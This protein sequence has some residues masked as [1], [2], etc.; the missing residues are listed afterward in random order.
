MASVDY[1]SAGVDTKKAASLIGS[2]KD[3]IHKTATVP[4][5]GKLAEGIGGF[6]GAFQHDQL[7]YDVVSTTDGVGTK[8]QLQKKYNRLPGV[9]YDLVAM[10]VNDLYCAGAVPAFFLDYVACGKLDESWY[11]PV[12]TSIAQACGSVPMALM[13][14][15]T[16]EHPGVMKDDDFDLAGFA[17]G[18]R[19]RGKAWPRLTEMK[20]EHVL[21][22]IP[23][24]GLHSN[25]F[26]LVRRILSL[27]EEQDSGRF[28]ALTADSDFMD[29]LLAPTRIYRG[30]EKLFDNENIFGAAHI[31]GGGIYENL[32]RVIPENLK[33]VF[34]DVRVPENSVYSLLREFTDLEDLFHTFNM[35]HGMILVAEETALPFVQTVFPD[36]WI[37][38][39]LQAGNRSIEIQG[40]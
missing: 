36:A 23:S 5:V 6:A 11:N 27:L 3:E 29:A 33:A 9:G 17:T 15:E 8:I 1:R 4:G 21:I 2:L 16:A 13:G 26:S 12:V 14:G 32:P 35:G 37:S 38:G 24:S 18:F 25:G 40:I 31:T 7:S 20:A 10:C 34:T 39:V 22:S 30:I 19:A 28:A